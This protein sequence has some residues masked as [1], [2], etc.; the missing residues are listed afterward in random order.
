M[1]SPPGPLPEC[2]WAGGACEA[3][4]G[5][6]DRPRRLRSRRFQSIR[7]DSRSCSVTQSFR[8]QQDPENQAKAGLSPGA[9][10]ES[11]SLPPPSFPVM[12]V[13]FCCMIDCPH[14]PQQES[15]GRANIGVA[16]P[17]FSFGFWGRPRCQRGF[18]RS[19]SWPSGLVLRCVAGRSTRRGASSQKRGSIR[20]GR[21]RSAAWRRPI[22][23]R[24]ARVR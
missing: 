7:R 16:P 21:A 6:A 15:A 2:A 1:R 14:H 22:G 3:G 20:S 8:F 17:L 10:T 12:L 13:V 24:R 4:P 5:P 9:P 23:A 11:R 18:M 19:A